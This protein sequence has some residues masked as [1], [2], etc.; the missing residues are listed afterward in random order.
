MNN[1]NDWNLLVRFVTGEG[2]IHEEEK[3]KEWMQ[4]NPDIRDLVLILE[5]IWKSSKSLAREVDTEEA[6]NAVKERAKFDSEI[7]QLN[8][9]KNP[10]SV[11]KSNKDS[12][13]RRSSPI[14]RCLRVAAVLILIT[15][16]SY[17]FT[18]AVGVKSSSLDLKVYGMEE[19]VVDY[20]K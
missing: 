15:S 18:K 7:I 16:G 9:E 5:K 12:Y 1:G 20:E 3:V 17:F 19:I 2:S 8:S 10:L 14:V 11:A 4:S 6:L 13:S